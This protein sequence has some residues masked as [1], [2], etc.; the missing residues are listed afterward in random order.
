M[1]LI[2][3]AAADGQIISKFSWSN[4]PVTRAD[5]GPDAISVSATATSSSGGFTG[6]GLNP[7][8]SSTDINLTLTG[9]YYDVP[10][11][12]ISFYFRR[13]E[14]EASFFKRGSNFNFAMTG[15]NLFATFLVSNGAGGSTT[16]NTGN[17]Y[18]IPNDHAFHNYR[19]RYTA[20]TGVTTVSV[21]GSVVYTS[22]G[23]ASRSMYWTGA[24]NAVIGSL[25]DGT[26]RNVP[27]LDEMVIQ[28]SAAAAA[29]PL[30]L[31][32]FTAAPKNGVIELK[33]ATDKEVGTKNFDIEKSVDGV[34]FKAI[35]SVATAGGYATVNNYHFADA[36]ATPWQQLLPP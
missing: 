22:T 4:N 5:V 12:D 3:A 23:T 27:V 16:I 13:E 32:S 14:N 8:T 15:G 2:V 21:D 30:N 17:I 10:G 35:G 28:N 11:L 24:G 18:A 9:S 29:L 34:S 25:M 6:N 33:W 1:F 36:S 31:L 19:F 20:A 26:G 7:G